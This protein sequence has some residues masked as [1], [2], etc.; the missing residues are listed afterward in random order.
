MPDG[1]RFNIVFFDD[2]INALSSGMIA[3]DPASRQ[4][5]IAFVERIQ[6]GGSTAAVPALRAAYESGAG[7]V[8][9]LSDGLP[10]T[11]GGADELL[12]EARVQIR[13]G[14][15]FDT[16]GIGLNQ[17]SK[18]MTELALEGGGLAIKR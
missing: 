12:A 18:L 1:T 16:V 14:V 13:T 11:G 6:P 10:N 3:L 15:R 17:D 5:A 9:L 8:V 2:H 4:N 7:R